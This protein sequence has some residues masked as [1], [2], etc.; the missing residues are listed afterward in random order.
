MRGLL[1]GFIGALAL[2]GL[3]DLGLRG[4]DRL[5]AAWRVR[6]RRRALRLAK[7]LHAPDPP[8]PWVLVTALC[9]FILGMA[10]LG[11]SV[12]TAPA[13]PPLPTRL[14]EE[15]RLQQPA[16][17]VPP[18]TQRAEATYYKDSYAGK[19]TASGELYDPTLYTAAHRTLPFG[20]HVEVWG[21][22]GATLARV[23]D[24]GPWCTHGP[25]CKLPCPRADID[26]SR[27]AAERIGLIRPGRAIVALRRVS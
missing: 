1:I 14:P 10:A 13:A 6:R 3:C 26:L 23:N 7:R 19:R 21:P 2:Y 16:P 15:I 11:L 9:L 8:F 25:T 18:P 17:H 4:W 24:R 27:A 5:S 12:P 20:D 22:G